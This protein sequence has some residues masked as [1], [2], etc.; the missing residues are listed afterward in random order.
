MTGIKKKKGTPILTGSSSRKE[1][2]NASEM[3]KEKN[4]REESEDQN[5]TEHK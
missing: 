3:K 4:Q 5:R 1:Q 2:T